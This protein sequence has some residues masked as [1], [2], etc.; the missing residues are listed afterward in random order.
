MKTAHIITDRI[1]IHVKKNQKTVPNKA[2]GWL[3]FLKFFVKILSIDP[4]PDPALGLQ[5]CTKGNRNVLN[6]ELNGLR[7]LSIF[8]HIPLQK[9]CFYQPLS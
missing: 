5:F 1:Q 3:R 8:K 6:T 7:K 9:G 4:D 2:L